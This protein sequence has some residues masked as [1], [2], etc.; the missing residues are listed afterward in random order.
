VRLW[1]FQGSE[2]A[3]A[4]YAKHG[5]VIVESIDGSGNEEGLPDLLL[6]LA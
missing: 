3:R 6:A 4:L 1:T 5:F 2:R